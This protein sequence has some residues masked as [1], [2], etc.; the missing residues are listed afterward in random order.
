MNYLF[1]PAVVAAYGIPRK[2]EL[3]LASVKPLTVPCAVKAVG[4]VGAVVSA[5]QL[6]TGAPA[7]RRVNASAMQMLC[8]KITGENMTAEVVEN[9]QTIEG[10]LARGKG[11]ICC[12][13]P[14]YY[15]LDKWVEHLVSI[16]GEDCIASPASTRCG[17]QA[18]GVNLES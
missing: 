7:T 17:M 9:C 16:K 6:Y 13:L 12:P 1:S 4:A 11:K 5:S 18:G 2:T 8:P 14:P 3:P 10:K 15:I